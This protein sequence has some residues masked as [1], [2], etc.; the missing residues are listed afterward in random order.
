MGNNRLIRFYWLLSS[1]QPNLVMES[2]QW[3]RMPHLFPTGH[4]APSPT[5][6]KI[7][8]QDSTAVGLCA[9]WSVGKRCTMCPHPRLFVA[10]ADVVEG[11]A[12]VKAKSK[13]ND[14]HLFC[15]SHLSR[16]VRLAVYMPTDEK[17]K[18]CTV[19]PSAAVEILCSSI[20]DGGGAGRILSASILFQDK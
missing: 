9:T 5:T 20:H 18:P 2:L 1:S 6:G 11:K 12:K 15:F 3:G 16:S 7:L 4:S 8:Q 13:T 10:S 14:L 19:S 17:K